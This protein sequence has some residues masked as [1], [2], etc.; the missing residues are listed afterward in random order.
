MGRIKLENNSYIGEITSLKNEMKDLNER[1]SSFEAEFLEQLK[2]KEDVIS[3]LR[4]D[5]E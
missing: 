4:V 3:E 1:K 2:N 5:L